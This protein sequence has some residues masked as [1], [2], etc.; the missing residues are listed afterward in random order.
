MTVTLN[1]AGL[2][3]LFNSP[4]VA[5]FVAGVASDVVAQA[6]LN[7]RGYYHSAPGLNVD[8][9]IGFSMEG[10]DAVIGIR[11][12]GEK[13]RRLARYQAQGNANGVVDWLLDAVDTVDGQRGT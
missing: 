8:Q 5:R 10:P 2:Q 4:P 9:D 6:Q 7:V 13:S 11:D 3:A 12:A 1:E